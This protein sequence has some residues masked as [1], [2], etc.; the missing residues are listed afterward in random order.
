[1][2][3]AYLG[4]EGSYTHA[5][6]INVFG[7]KETLVPMS[8]I[9]SIISDLALALVDQAIIPVENSIAGGVAETIE[10]LQKSENLFVTSEY[11]LPIQ[12]HLLAAK[13]TIKK[14]QLDQVKYISLHNMTLGQCLDYIRSKMPNAEILPATSNSAAAK[15]LANLQKEGKDVSNHVVI[16]PKLCAEIYDLEILDDS[17]SDSKINETR[18]W[19]V[20]KSQSK[21]NPAAKNKTTIVFQTKDEPGSLQTVLRLF[22]VNHVN[23]SRIESRPAKKQIGEYMFLID[24]DLHIE[25]KKYDDLMRQ[26]KQQFTYYKW[27]GS[28]STI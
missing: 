2:K 19:I 12:H 5:A 15:E 21:F 27:L 18:F 10:A 20:S 23:L 13:N 6:A 14:N 17:V 26:A 25:D 8:N 9:S 24:F 4:P 16:A 28:Y 22:A 7:M 11:V 3:I 1:M